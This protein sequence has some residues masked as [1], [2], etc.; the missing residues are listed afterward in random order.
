M[1]S[2][3]LCKITVK[4]RELTAKYSEDTN[5]YVV[6]YGD[7]EL[8]RWDMNIMYPW[9]REMG[10]NLKL[11]IELEMGRQDVMEYVDGFVKAGN[12]L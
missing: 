6:S 9:A 7:L 10:R 4:G 5:C 3:T 1:K 2:Y 8:R 12:L 11:P